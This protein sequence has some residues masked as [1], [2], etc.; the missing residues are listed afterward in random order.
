MTNLKSQ[1]ED[2]KCF[3]LLR[4]LAFAHHDF[5]SFKINVLYAQ[6]QRIHQPQARAVEQT[7][8]VAV[9]QTEALTPRPRSNPLS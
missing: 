3:P 2:G 4:S 6:A 5:V 8:D 7:R 1:M 9:T